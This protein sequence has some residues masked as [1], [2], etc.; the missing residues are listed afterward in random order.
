MFDWN[1]V[2]DM[3]DRLDL[4]MSIINFNGND[5]IVFQ[6]KVEKISTKNIRKFNSDHDLLKYLQRLERKLKLDRVNDK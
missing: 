6:Y 3:L 5:N 2:D 1:I 4:H